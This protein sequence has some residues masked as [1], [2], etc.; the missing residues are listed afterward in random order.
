MLRPFPCHSV[1]SV[2]CW[3]LKMDGGYSGHPSL[4]V[5]P[6]SISFQFKPQRDWLAEA[7]PCCLYSVDG[8]W[9]IQGWT[10]LSNTRT[11]FIQMSTASL[12]NASFPCSCVANKPVLHWLP[13]QSCCLRAAW[14]THSGWDSIHRDSLKPW[15]WC[16]NWK[17]GGYVSL[18]PRGKQM[19]AQSDR[20]WPWVTALL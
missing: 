7:K 10:W 4:Q 5:H 8:P 12:P 19:F 17:Q 9:V 6:E 11:F 15:E 13:F 16:N 18:W 2:T 20:W 14:G 3:A 1:G